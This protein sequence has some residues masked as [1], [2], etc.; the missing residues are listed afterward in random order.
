MHAIR[1]AGGDVSISFGGYIGVEL[2]HSKGCP[3]VNS[4]VNAYQSVIDKY[5]LTNIDFDIEGDD[6]GDITGENHRFKAIKILK[7]RAKSKRKQLFISLTLPTT[8]V[9]LSDLSRAEIKRAIDDG[10]VIDLYKAMYE[11]VF[12]NKVIMSLMIKFH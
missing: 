7:D 3:D 5:E 10:V 8:T 12:I 2:G 9:G 1:A 11:L 6:L 4:L